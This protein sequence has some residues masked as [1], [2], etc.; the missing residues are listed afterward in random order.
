MTVV[1]EVE[2]HRLRLALEH[3]DG[4][5]LDAT[6][7]APADRSLKRLY[8][9]VVE[10]LIAVSHLEDLLVDAREPAPAQDGRE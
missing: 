5:L 1:S 4:W 3:A 8:A 9:V 6:A 10:G 2:L 7:P